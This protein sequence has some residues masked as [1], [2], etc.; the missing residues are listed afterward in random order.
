MQNYNK[1]SSFLTYLHSLSHPTYEQDGRH[2]QWPLNKMFRFCNYLKNPQNEFKIIHIAGTNGKGS[3]VSIIA[4]YLMLL[5]YKVG[6]YTSPELFDVRER[7][8][9]NGHMIQNE[10]IIDFYDIIQEYISK[11][12]EN[13]F[14][15]YSQVFVCLAFY[16][17]N[18]HNIDFAIIETGIG[19]TNDPT[20]VVT[21]IASVIT[22]IGLDHTDVFG[23][24]ILDI[25]KEKS[26]IIKQCIPVVLGPVE[27]HLRSFVEQFADSLEAPLYSTDDLTILDDKIYQGISQSSY[28]SENMK[29][30]Y[31]VLS[32]LASRGYT[33]PIED[34]LFHK[35]LSDYRS[36][37]GLYGRWDYVGHSPDIIVDICDNESSAKK[38]FS[39]VKNL[40]TKKQY[41][42]V[43]I[44][45]GLTG[46]RKLSMLKYFPKNAIYYYTE[47]H[48]FISPH[49]VKMALSFPGNCYSQTSL[50]IDEYM[51]EKASND[52]VLILG[53]IHIISEA[54]HYFNNRGKNTNAVN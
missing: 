27:P 45:F 15:T 42:R 39:D 49:E 17:F 38:V 51:K 37:F 1:Y 10:D 46:P 6:T 20:N 26:G 2:Y 4:R 21:P 53:S 48:G 31:K 34:S 12:L 33:P 8:R 43:V 52:L 16:Y 11:D 44:I 47:S 35:A 13:S 18:K 23:D 3:C 14:D 24:N 36:V 30:C 9:L 19:G 54:L 28:Q 50:A 22:S 5:G 25:A 7:V 32:V 29:T 41:S 40:C